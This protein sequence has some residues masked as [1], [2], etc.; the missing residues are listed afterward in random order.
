LFC[1]LVFQSSIS[2]RKLAQNQMSDSGSDFQIPIRLSVLKLLFFV[3]ENL[4]GLWFGF[5]LSN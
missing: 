1:I 2:I 5:F 4:A 3:I